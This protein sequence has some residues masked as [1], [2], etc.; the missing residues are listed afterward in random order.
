MILCSNPKAQYL[1]RKEEINEAIASVLEHGRYILGDQVQQFEKEF[2]EFV[3]VDFG[4]GV[5]SGTEALHLALRGCGIGVGDEIITVSHTAVA[6]VAAIELAGARPVF[7]DID[8]RYYTLAPEH[9]A[10]AL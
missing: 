8:P 9:L 10:S 6:T 7:V 3:G 1:A 2:A 4:I 5:G